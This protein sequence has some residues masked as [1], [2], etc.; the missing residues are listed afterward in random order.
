TSKICE[1]SI[2]KFRQQGLNIVYVKRRS[3]SGFKAGALQHALN[4]SDGE[5]IAVFDADFVP[6]KDFL[7]K[8]LPYFVDEK[9]GVVQARWAHLNREY[10]ILTAAQALSLDLHFVV[11]QRGRM[12]GGLFLN[13][14]GTA[15]VWRRKCIEDA[16]GWVDSLAEDL[17]L[18]YRAQLKGWKIVYVDSLTVPAEIPVQMSA[19][20]R[21][22]YRWAY[23]AVQTTLRYIWQVLSSPKPMYVKVHAF[24]H[25]TRHVPQL[26][27]VI[28]VILVP[29]VAQKLLTRF[30]WMIGWM[31]LYPILLTISLLMSVKP[32]ID[33][34]YGNTVSFVKDVLIAFF[35]GLGMS[36]N[37]AL[38]VV[39]A[40][41]RRET[42]FERTPKFGIVNKDGEW[43]TSSYVVKTDV[44]IVFDIAVGIYA[45]Y[46]SLYCFYSQAYAFLPLT[47]IF[48]I[49]L[50]YT[51]LSSMMQKPIQSTAQRKKLH[52]AVVAAS[53]V[54]IMVFAVY[55]YAV[56][57]HP[58][59]ETIALLER[60]STS[61]EI[62]SITEKIQ[63]AL[64]K[65]PDRGNPVWLF[66][67]A[68]TDYSL[69]KHD[70]Q[71]IQKTVTT[72]QN[73][74]LD[75]LHAIMEDMRM[76]LQELKLQ[77]KT[78][79][80]YVWVDAA[81]IPILLLAAMSLVYGLVR[82]T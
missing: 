18:S 82:E 59:E 57:V 64:A 74:G 21:Q 40:L 42:G 70:L 38:A 8:I 14:N 29:L 58:L 54:F 69:I 77:L 51:S 73:S 46:A 22:H 72:I 48:A 36:V 50:L 60:A 81:S 53:A 13:F 55:S 5:F 2:W 34:S 10:S 76:S 43:K 19:V 33:T 30:E 32:V 47:T 9:V 62:T 75:Y 71:T 26:L 41:S 1:E 12:A 23:G 35:W 15:G 68:K 80:P 61:T 56:L 52:V 79:E 6:Q 11:E 4:I 24:I 20:R 37:N 7:K 31:T 66:P 63:Q 78:V 44:Y 67:T 17:D 39:H 3:R 45:L 65:L 49:A 28:Q 25:L 27:L 16:G